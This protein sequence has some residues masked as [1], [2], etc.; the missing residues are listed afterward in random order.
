MS[1]EYTG[2]VLELVYLCKA[3]NEKEYLKIKD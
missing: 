3:G 1:Y 2:M